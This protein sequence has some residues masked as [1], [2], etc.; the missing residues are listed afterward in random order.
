MSQGRALLNATGNLE[1]SGAYADALKR[2]G[3]ELEDVA[4][5]VRCF[6]D[7]FCSI[8]MADRSPFFGLQRRCSNHSFM[9]RLLI[10]ECNTNDLIIGSGKLDFLNSK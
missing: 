2:L 1:L 8:I 9:P 5:Q 4:G 6:Y 7:K 3:H 10:Y